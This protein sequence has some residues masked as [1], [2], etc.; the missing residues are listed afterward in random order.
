MVDFYYITTT[1]GLFA[2]MVQRTASGY[3]SPFAYTLLG[4]VQIYFGESGLIEQKALKF[5]PTLAIKKEQPHGCS[6][7]MVAQALV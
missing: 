2:P 4:L 7:F 6:F 1:S 5:N 3:W